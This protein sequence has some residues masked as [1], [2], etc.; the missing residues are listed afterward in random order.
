[1]DLNYTDADLAFRDE[2]RAFLA[3]QLPADLQ[4]KVRKHLRMS[5]EDYVR[6]H[7]ILAAKGWVAPGWPRALLRPRS[8]RRWPRA[9][10]SRH[11]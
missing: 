3:E 9:S 7:R 10:M 4:A 8:P 6:W 11:R 1:M 2:V 5:K